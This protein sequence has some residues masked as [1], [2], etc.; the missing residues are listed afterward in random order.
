MKLLVKKLAN[1]NISIFLRNSLNFIINESK[2]QFTGM[3]KFFNEKK[4]YGFIQ[5][6]NNLGEIF[7]II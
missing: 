3:L 5:I 4:N 2:E 6:D 1:M 7:V